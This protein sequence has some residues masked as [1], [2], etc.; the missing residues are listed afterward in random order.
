MD[1][2]IITRGCRSNTDDGSIEIELSEPSIVLPVYLFEVRCLGL[3]NL[4]L[5][6]FRG[7][8]LDHGEAIG[9]LSRLLGQWERWIST[10]TC[11]VNELRAGRLRDRRPSSS[12]EYMLSASIASL[13]SVAHA[14]GPGPAVQRNG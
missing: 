13:H 11:S 3:G 2:P 5:G 8:G 6:L 14:P 1:S 10:R 12:L 9:V 4:D 7:W